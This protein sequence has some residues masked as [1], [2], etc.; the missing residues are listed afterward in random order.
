ML[1]DRYKE[2]KKEKMNSLHMF[3]KHYDIPDHLKTEV[4]SFYNHLLK[5][6]TSDQDDQIMNDLPTGLQ[7]EVQIFMLIKLIRDIHV[8]QNASVECLKLVA[9]KMNHT[10]YSPGDLVVKTGDTGSEMFIIAHGEVEVL[11]AGNVVAALKPGQFFGEIALLEE[12]T[13]SADVRSKA[14]CD[15][16]TFDKDDFLDVCKQFPDLKEKF[17]VILERRKSDN[18][19]REKKAA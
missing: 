2:E 13:R 4:F 7:N 11:I 17:E 16:Y 6:K 3:L 15:M 12:T 9:T 10:F 8:F 1:A 14:Y 18:A 5:Q 19:A